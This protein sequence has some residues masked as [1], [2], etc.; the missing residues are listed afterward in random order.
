MNRV[1]AAAV[2]GVPLL[3]AAAACAVDRDVSQDAIRRG[4]STDIDEARRPAST[5]ARPILPE[6]VPP[7]SNAGQAPSSPVT[8]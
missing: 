8:R 5:D 2:L 7:I 6:A 4:I 3:L 1:A